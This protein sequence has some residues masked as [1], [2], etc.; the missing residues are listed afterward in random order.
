MPGCASID[1]QRASSL[2]GE[3]ARTTITLCGVCKKACAT[4]SPRN[5][6][7]TNSSGAGSQREAGDRQPGHCRK[8]A[9]L[10]AASTAWQRS[11]EPS[12]GFS[13]VR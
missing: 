9:A 12:G 7:P 2:A 10:S 4:A 8:T 13:T 6:C 5:A 3:S 11:G 1:W